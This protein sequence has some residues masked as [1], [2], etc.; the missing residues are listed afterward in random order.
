M[1]IDKKKAL[2]LVSVA[3]RGD[4]SALG[5]LLR[6]MIDGDIDMVVGDL[7]VDSLT[8]ANSGVLARTGRQIIIPVGGNAK[9]GATAGWVITAGT[10]R[11]H[12]TLPASQTNSTLIIPIPGLEVGD[13]V[14]GV[15]VKGQVESGGN[16]VTLAAD[17][18]KQTASAAADVTDASLGTAA[19]AAINADGVVDVE[20]DITPTAEV[21][22]VDEQLYLKITGTTAASTDVDITSIVVTV[23]KR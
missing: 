18:R 17:L 3:E 12:A 11:Y 2:Q 21:M 23:N 10:D 19:P 20:L 13:I 8:I 15:S 6:A 1:S 9:V 16:N 22:A 4:M 14:T 5:I 7:T